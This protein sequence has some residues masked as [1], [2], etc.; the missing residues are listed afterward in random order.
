MKR[1]D[2]FF[3][4]HFDFHADDTMKE[5]GKAFDAETLERIITEVK[6]DYIQCDS[7]GHM[8]YS[9]YPTKVGYPAP[10]IVA[11]M[12][13]G[14]REVTKKHGVLLFAHHSG[15]WDCT[16]LAH[17][18]EWSAL[19]KEGSPTDRASVFGQYADAFLIPQLKELAIDYGLDGAWV[20]GECWSLIE[21]YSDYAE[22][23]WKERTGKSLSALTEEDRA[24]FLQFNRDGF[25]SYV[26]HYV[27]EV[28]KAAPNFEITSNWLSTAFVPDNLTMIDFISGDIAGISPVD[29]TRF[30]ARLIAAQGMPWDLMAWGFSAPMDTMQVKSGIQLCQEA[31]LVISLGGGF[32]FV[33]VQD[34]R[35]TVLDDW[36]IPTW[37]E[38]AKFCRA[39]QPYYQGGKA[40][41]DIGVLYSKKAHYAQDMLI[42]H[43]SEYNLEH[44]GVVNLLCDNGK[45]ISVFLAE[46][47]DEVDLSAYDTIVVTDLKDLEKAAKDKLLSYVREGGK[48]FVIGAAATEYFADE[49]S[50]VCTAAQKNKACRVAGEG[51]VWDMRKPYVEISREKPSDSTYMTEHD[52]E[53]VR[54]FPSRINTLRK[55]ELPAF[56]TFAEGAGRVGVLPI[57]LGAAYFNERSYELAHFM[58]A[59]LTKLDAGR[60]SVSPKGWVDGLLMQN[61]GRTFVHLINILGDHRSD[62]VKTFDRIPTV[63]GAKI[64]YKTEKAP[65]RV[66]LQPEGKE[67]AF[68]YEQ[69]VLQVQTD[70][71]IYS[72]LEIVE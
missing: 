65:R 67:L 28:K 48:L 49:F 51:Y 31:A 41:P 39:R 19:N 45:S 4:L 70:V 27:Q 72:I 58:G 35:R 61:K 20:D 36:A 66:L 13:K 38:V 22:K 57:T 11:D 15:I 7:K 62:R 10:D 6:P 3:G 46:L 1:K 59:C 54:I 5:L 43:D 56:M 53:V 37:A 32:Q 50:I 40:L 21:D 12:L 71:E 60:F 47:I 69:G 23:A 30:D 18:P 33:N 34:A 16:A 9:S 24:E 8:G 68:T 64:F 52:A 63:N 14:W 2:C 55:R 44:R 25:F 42:S 26:E 29:N 17:H